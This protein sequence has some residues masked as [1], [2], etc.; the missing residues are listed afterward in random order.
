MWNALKILPSFRYTVTLG[1]T[2]LTVR[3]LSEFG[4]L[5]TTSEVA[6]DL[7]DRSDQVKHKMDD[8]KD[9]LG[10]MRGKFEDEWEKSWKRFAEKRKK[11]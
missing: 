8:F 3:K 1:G 5:K 4:W 11:P 6:S 7:R 9:S 10:D 2:T